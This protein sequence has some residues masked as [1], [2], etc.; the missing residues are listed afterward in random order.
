MIYTHGHPAVPYE[1]EDTLEHWH[2]SIRAFHDEEEECE[3]GCT[4]ACDR[5]VKDG[6]EVGYVGLWRLRD[7]TGADRWMVADAESGDLE[8]IAAAVLDNG[9]YSAAF[10]E[11]IE[12]PVGICSSWTGCSWPSP[13]ADSA[14]ARCS[15][16]KPSAGCLAD[17]AR[18]L[19]NPAW[20][21]GPITGKR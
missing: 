7:Y 8:S 3:G 15:R 16:Q 10:E 2:V 13:G 21:N 1:D 6:S 19:P 12:C 9:E 18:W 4:E 17:A 20:P 5:L 14:W 11:A